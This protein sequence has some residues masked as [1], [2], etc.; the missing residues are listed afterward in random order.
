MTGPQINRFL[1]LLE[2]AVK[3]GE[4]FVDARYPV[5]DEGQGYISKAGAPDK[6]QTREEY[7]AFEP[8]VGRFERKLNS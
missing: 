8:E 7:E 6:P 3:I 2:S 5:P 1:D 4:R